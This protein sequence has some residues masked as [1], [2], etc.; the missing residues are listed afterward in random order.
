MYV[1]FQYKTALSKVQPVARSLSKIDPKLLHN[2]HEA[3]NCGVIGGSKSG[4]RHP[5]AL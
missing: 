1:L 3:D 2:F 4:S 5:G